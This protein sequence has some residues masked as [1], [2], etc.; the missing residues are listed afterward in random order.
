MFSLLQ[1]VLFCVSSPVCSPPWLIVPLYSN[2]VSDFHFLCGCTWCFCGAWCCVVWVWCAFGCVAWCFAAASSFSGVFSVV[3][4]LVSVVSWLL[5]WFWCV[6]LLVRL[7]VHVFLLVCLFGVVGWLLC[8]FVCSAVLVLIAGVCCVG[9]VFGLLLVLCCVAL[10]R[11]LLVAAAPGWFMLLLVGVGLFSSP[12][13]GWCVLILVCFAP[14][15]FCGSLV[16][17]WCWL[18]RFFAPG[19]CGGW[20]VLVLV[21]AHD[22][23]FLAPGFLLTQNATLVWWLCGVFC[24]WRLVVPLLVVSASVFS[25]SVFVEPFFH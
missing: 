11:F 16:V 19:A 5:L 23:R 25:S 15:V 3:L 10:F 9:F 1:L 8:C 2:S 14:G 12:G 20:L 24:S 17:G 21:A 22:Q 7:L 4:S 18:V 6:G 13:V